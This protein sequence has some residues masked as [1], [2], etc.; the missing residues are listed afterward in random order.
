MDREITNYDAEGICKIYNSLRKK[1]AL[2]DKSIYK[3][4]ISFSVLDC[5]SPGSY[6]FDYISE[7]MEEKN[8]LIN[9]KIVIDGCIDRLEMEDRQMIML[10]IYYAKLTGEEICGILDLKA[11]TMYRRI[12]QAYKHFAEI[13][14]KSKHKERILKVLER[15]TIKAEIE[16]VEERRKAF[17]TREKGQCK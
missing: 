10:K 15:P 17:K 3:A 2:I 11:R 6:V 14:N 5:G 16:D 7:L 4:G 12:E 8:K 13:L 9:F 1:C